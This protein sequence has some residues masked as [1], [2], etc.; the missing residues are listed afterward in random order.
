MSLIHGIIRLQARHLASQAI[1]YFYLVS[2]AVNISEIVSHSP[3]ILKFILNRLS[4]FSLLEKTKNSWFQVRDLSYHAAG[5]FG[6]IV[7]LWRS[8]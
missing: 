1:H 6:K 7:T 3:K 4:M 5:C 8:I 2:Y